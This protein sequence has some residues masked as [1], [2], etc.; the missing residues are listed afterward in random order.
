MTKRCFSVDKI[1]LPILTSKGINNEYGKII[2][3]KA[4]P[5]YSEDINTILS[6]SKNNNISVLIMDDIIIFGRTINSLIEQIM[7]RVEMS[8]D[9]LLDKVLVRCIWQNKYKKKIRKVCSSSG[10]CY[11]NGLEKIIL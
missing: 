7:S 9:Q 2:S 5:F 8:Q 3:D 4:L 6:D 11:K 1:F 10:V